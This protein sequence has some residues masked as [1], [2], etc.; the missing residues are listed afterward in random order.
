MGWAQD[1]HISC[2]SSQGATQTISLSWELVRK[3]ESLDSPLSY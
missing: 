3:A 1:H 2:Y